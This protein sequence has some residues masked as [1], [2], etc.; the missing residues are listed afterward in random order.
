MNFENIFGRYTFV[1]DVDGHCGFFCDFP[2][3]VY[4]FI[5]QTAAMTS[6]DLCLEIYNWSSQISS[7]WWFQIFFYVHPYLGKISNLTNILQRG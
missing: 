3:A 7:W 2:V 6:I 5:G 4:E 1:E